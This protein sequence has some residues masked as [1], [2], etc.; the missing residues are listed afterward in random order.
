MPTSLHNILTVFFRALSVEEDPQVMDNLGMLY[1]VSGRHQEGRALYQYL[2]TNYPDRNDTKLHYA[3]GSA[4]LLPRRYRI[5]KGISS[6]SQTSLPLRNKALIQY[7]NILKFQEVSKGEAA[8]AF[9][10]RGWGVGNNWRVL[11]HY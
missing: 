11:L 7:S 10:L 3:L 2:L 9:H 6:S 1:L 4:D 5:S 8:D